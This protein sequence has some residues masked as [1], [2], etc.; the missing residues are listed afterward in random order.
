MTT[1]KVRTTVRTGIV[2]LRVPLVGHLPNQLY[3][4][5]GEG[6]EICNHLVI[7]RVERIGFWESHLVPHLATGR[8]GRAQKEKNGRNKGVP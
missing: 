8:Q 3:Q 7:C 4:H 6:E 5:T 2:L 1:R